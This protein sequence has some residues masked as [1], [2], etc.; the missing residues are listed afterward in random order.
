MP[1]AAFDYDN[2]PSEP[3][4]D[5]Q[6][7]RLQTCWGHMELHGEHHKQAP[8]PTV[9]VCAAKPISLDSGLLTAPNKRV[10]GQFKVNAARV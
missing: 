4:V 7:A 2:L 3:R 10:A 6:R 1:L 5:L 9:S 8:G